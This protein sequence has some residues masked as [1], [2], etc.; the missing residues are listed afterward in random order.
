MTNDQ[1]MELADRYQDAMIVEGD[2]LIGYEF[3][4]NSII[5]FARLIQQAQRE[6]D[7]QVVLSRCIGYAVDDY[8]LNTL[9]AAI[10]KG[11]AA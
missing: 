10:R 1:I 9:A 2:D 5:A 4:L 8:D 7:A 6:E 11:G 3:S